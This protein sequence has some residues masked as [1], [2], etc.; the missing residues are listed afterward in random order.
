MFLPWADNFCYSRADQ[1]HS[2]LSP[3]L[4]CALMWKFEL[5]HGRTHLFLADVPV[6]CLGNFYKWE[7]QIL[8]CRSLFFLFFI[9]LCGALKSP[10]LYNSVHE[11]LSVPNSY[12]ESFSCYLGSYY[13]Y[14]FFM[15]SHTKSNLLIVKFLYADNHKIMSKTQAYEKLMMENFYFFILIC[16]WKCTWDGIIIGFMTILLM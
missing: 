5:V 2:F 4:A 10:A 14:P 11:C 8:Y 6:Y 16:Q 1:N 13:L 15:T 9:E 12:N 3:S 7:K